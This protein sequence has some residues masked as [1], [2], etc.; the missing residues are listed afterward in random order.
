MTPQE[1]YDLHRHYCKRNRAWCPTCLRLRAE[2]EKDK[3][4]P[5]EPHPPQEE[6]HKG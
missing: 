2:M 4:P 5:P 1:R 3:A 6:E